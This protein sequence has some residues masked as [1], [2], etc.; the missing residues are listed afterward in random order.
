MMLRS[1]FAVAGVMAVAA[2]TMLSLPA[3]AQTRPDLRKLPSNP[4]A[5]MVSLP[6]QLNYE[7]G[8]GADGDG[9]R[10]VLNVQPIVPI[11]L[12]EKWN[13]VSRTIV[14][15]IKQTHPRNPRFEVS[16]VGD[17]LQSVFLSPKALTANGWNW[18]AGVAVRV[19]TATDQRLGADQWAAGPTA[20]AVTLTDNG[21][22]LGVL[23]NHLWSVNGDSHV[24]AINHS[25]V[26]PFL[27]KGLSGPYSVSANLEGSYGWQQAQ[28]HVPLN[29]TLNRL[30][31]WGNQR[32]LLQGGLRYQAVAPDTAGE[33]G[34]R[35]MLTFLYPEG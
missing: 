3:C 12:G 2:T 20:V 27:T 35:L 19:P 5:N 21:W 6:L 23:V 28:W 34:L 15:L 14:P 16:G 32:V 26:Q 22:V 1:S 25:F 11:S 4:I 10:T 17:T 31:R 18:G 30:D 13:L 9:H 7:T 24:A 8:L 29:L 33:W